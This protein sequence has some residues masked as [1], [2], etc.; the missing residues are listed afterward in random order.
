M[1]TVAHIKIIIDN[2]RIYC[3]FFSG[4]SCIYNFSKK[5]R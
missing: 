2:K 4:P 5:M 3:P 1:Y